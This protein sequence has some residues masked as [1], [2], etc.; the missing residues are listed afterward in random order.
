MRAFISIR[1]KSSILF[2][3]VFVL[4]I[5]PVNFV[6][7]KKVGDSLFKADVRELREEAVK[8]AFRVRLDPPLIPLPLKGYLLKIQIEQEP[9]N[10]NIFSSPGF[11]ELPDS[12]YYFEFVEYDTLR[13]INH[14]GGSDD[15]PGLMLSLAR[16]D[17]N[18]QTELTDLRLYLFA[19]SFASIALAGM[20]VYLAAGFVVRPIQRIIEA[21]G[22]VKVSRSMDRVPVPT[23]KDENRELAQTINTMLSRM[24]DSINNQMNFF[25]SASHE[26][27][28]PLAVMQTELS[29]ARQQVEDN[30][31]KKALENSLY[32]VKRLSRVV[33]DFLLISQL[34]S[35]SLTL[36][37][38]VERIDEILYGALKRL[39]YAAQDRQIRLKVNVEESI[40]YTTRCDLDKIETVFTNLVENAIKYAVENSTISITLASQQS[41]CKFV[42]VNCVNQHVNDPEKLL[43]EFKKP[44]HLNSGLGMGLWICNEIVKLHD[45]NLEIIQSDKLFSVTIT[46][47]ALKPT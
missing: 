17:K 13:I 8:L 37:L 28:T 38:H 46:L 5:L 2:F 9:Q 11:P 18:L 19:A 4:I 22:K 21:A 10:V 47:P 31:S 7:Y 24:E 32:E 42:I 35:E 29:L 1:T 12:D 20:L 40:D 15:V 44:Q 36:R 33:S 6:I 25:A 41:A 30:A 45:G 27:K 39:K 26:L 16:S 14:R 43:N 23:S 34:K 3:V